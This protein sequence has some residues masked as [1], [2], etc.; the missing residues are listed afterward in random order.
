MTEIGLEARTKSTDEN[1][2][3]IVTF[4]VEEI[5]HLQSIV[6]QLAFQETSKALLASIASGKY[7]FGQEVYHPEELSAHLEFLKK[8]GYLLITGTGKQTRLRVT[9]KGMD[10]ISTTETR[11]Y[12]KMGYKNIKPSV[13]R[14]IY[15]W[16]D[17]SLS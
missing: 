11:D 6:S 1:S 4:S 7:R 16:L 17:V 13:I 2:V 14:R 5:R 3:E 15:D 8:E 12:F 9:P 10:A